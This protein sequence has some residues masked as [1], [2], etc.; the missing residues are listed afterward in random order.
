MTTSSIAIKVKVEDKAKDLPK[1]PLTKKL[2]IM[3]GHL[4]EELQG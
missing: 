1:H 3:F 2:K 4:N